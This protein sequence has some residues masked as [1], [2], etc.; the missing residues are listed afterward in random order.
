MRE[1]GRTTT[2]P[3]VDLFRRGWT[4]IIRIIL[5]TFYPNTLGYITLFF[6]LS[7]GTQTLHFSRSTLLT[8]VIVS[9]AC[10][11]TMTLYSGALSDRLGRSVPCCSVL[12]WASS[13]A[14]CS[15][16]WSTRQFR[17]WCFWRS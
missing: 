6:I 12:A 1:Q 7:Y 2:V 11:V 15:S 8:F 4:M 9:N 13:W 16:R 10:E 5:S 3:L 17:V 14:R